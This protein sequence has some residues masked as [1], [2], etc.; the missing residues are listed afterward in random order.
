MIKEVALWWRNTKTTAK[1]AVLTTLIN[2]SLQINDS[3]YK[4]N[5]KAQHVEVCDF[6]FK[7]F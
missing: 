4:I 3:I 2:L 5:L 6:T 1:A 7:L